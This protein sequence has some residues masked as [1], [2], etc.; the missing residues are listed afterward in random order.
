MKVAPYGFEHFS[1]REAF[2]YLTSGKWGVVMQFVELTPQST[3]VQ[4]LLN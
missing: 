1:L 4:T 2:G 3:I